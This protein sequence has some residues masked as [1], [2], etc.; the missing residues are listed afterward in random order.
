MLSIPFP[1]L[2]PFEAS[3]PCTMC[4]EPIA[5]A[6]DENIEVDAVESELPG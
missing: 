2:H 6:D 5:V 1:V 4:A 3:L